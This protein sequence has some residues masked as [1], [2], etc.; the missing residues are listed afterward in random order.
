MGS[1]ALLPSL[2]DRQYAIVM[3]QLSNRLATGLNASRFL[4]MGL[5]FLQSRV[6]RPVIGQVD[7]L[8]GDGAN[9][10]SPCQ[11]I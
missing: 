9:H 6:Y 8:A 1:L 2:S 3:R 7:R 5:V 10:A 4:G 11:G